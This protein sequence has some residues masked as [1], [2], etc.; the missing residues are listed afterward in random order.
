MAIK[1][2]FAASAAAAVLAFSGAA[3]AQ[4][5]ATAVTDLN[6]RA[7]PGPQHEIIGVI[8]ANEQA[9]VQGCLEASKWCRVSH[10]GTEGWAYGDY[11]T[12]EVSGSQV[13]VAERRSDVGVPVV[14]Y[15]GGATAGAATGAIAGALIGGPIG[16]VAG[17]VIGGAAGAA[18][19]APEQAV[20]YVRENRVDPVFLEGEV[21]VGARL[22]AEVELHE[23]PDAE[24][25]YVYVNGLPVLVNEE[26]QIVYV[27][28]Q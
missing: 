17:G 13:V 25:R 28:R 26:R 18:M 10:D 4:A 23:I 21:V 2:S 8:G 9:S 7:G 15:E 3:W 5:T 27:V 1:T 6:I 16:A 19:E 22:P 20:T 12:A 24:F 14:T 11:L